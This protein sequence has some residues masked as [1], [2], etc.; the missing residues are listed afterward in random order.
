VVANFHRSWARRVR[1][2]DIR[3][4]DTEHDI[5][6]LS[7]N[8]SDLFIVEVVHNR[9]TTDRS[10]SEHSV[11][12]PFLSVVVVFPMRGQNT[13]V[14]ECIGTDDRIANEVSLVRNVNR[15]ERI[16]DFAGSA[17]FGL[18]VVVKRAVFTEQVNGVQVF[19]V[20]AVHNL[21]EQRGTL[22]A[23][24]ISKVT[25][26]EKLQFGVELE[27]VRFEFTRGIAVTGVLCESNA[28]TAQGEDANENSFDHCRS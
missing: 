15:V 8:S 25:T 27:G 1:N 5:E 24:V 26:A 6:E 20:R 19:F 9:H 21:L 23:G 18:Q 10:V 11:P 28:H 4:G 16:T 17:N 22:F 2:E 14:I 3:V 7:V 12:T 13:G